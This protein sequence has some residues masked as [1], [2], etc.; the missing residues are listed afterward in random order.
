M[1]HR[2][3]DII[4]SYVTGAECYVEKDLKLFQ[5][6]QRFYTI[7]ALAYVYQLANF[8]GLTSCGSKDIFKSAPSLMYQY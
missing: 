7:T 6:I 2:N 1:K 3:L 5:I 8:G 4:G